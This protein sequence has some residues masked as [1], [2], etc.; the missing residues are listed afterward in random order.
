ML[1]ESNVQIKPEITL[2]EVLDNGAN[3][4]DKKSNK[5]TIGAD[6]IVTCTGFSPKK[7]EANAFKGIAPRFYAVGDCVEVRR[8]GPAI[9]EGYFAA[10]NL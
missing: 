1:K 9:H 5:L 6:N 2:T 3:F 4:L 10:Y 7:D 8:V